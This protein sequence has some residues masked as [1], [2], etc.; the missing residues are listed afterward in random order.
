LPAKRIVGLGLC[1]IDYLYR[2]DSLGLSETR[3]RWSERC[4]ST[5]GMACNATVQA[6]KLGCRSSLLSVIGEDPEGDFLE[7]S[8]RDAK[9]ETIG[10]V[11]SRGIPTTAALVLVDEGTGQRRFIV[12]DRRGIERN[13]PALDLGVIDRGS[14][15][16]LDGHFPREALR[17]AK[18]ARA[19]GATVI[20]D[21]SRPQ[22]AAP[23]LLP[24]VDFPIVPQEFARV[25]GDGD[26]RR[27]L[28]RL[29]DRFGG[30]PVVTQG[31]RGGIYWDGRR[32]RRYPAR[33]V[34]VRDT[35]GAGDAFHG[36]FAA[37]LYHG[38]D[39]PRA[40]ALAA[41]AAARCCTALGGVTRLLNRDEVAA[42]RAGKR[43][44]S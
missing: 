24:Y 23:A 41:R 39:L 28:R 20:G 1:V 40:I 16:M 4:M 9:V 26:A 30:T 34:A 17:A 25:Y 44:L 42:L 14:V 11:R 3:T 5:G 33:R 18:Q 35:T 38:L 2:V 12:P 32:I 22:G 15:L 7:R 6:A 10:L 37:G 29:R 36:A 31:A 21:F 13:A 19:V 8:L 43:R 27:A